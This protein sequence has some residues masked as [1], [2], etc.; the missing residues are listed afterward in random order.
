MNYNTIII[1]GGQAGL[2]VARYLKEKGIDY[3]VLDKEKEIG[4]SWKNRYD[5]L[6]LDSFAKY[7]KLENFPF[8]GNQKRQP[9]KDEVAEY[10]KSFAEFYDIKP[11]FDTEVY[12]IEKE[13]DDFIIKTN[14]DTYK[15]KSVVI[16]TGPFNTPY[17]PEYAYFISTEIY[18]LHAKNYKN[19]SEIPAGKILVVGGGNSGSEIA[20]ELVEN[21]RDIIFSFKG[22]LKSIPSSEFSQWIAYRLGIAHI[23]Q[24]SILGKIVRW[25]TKGK[26]VGMD[27]G[28]L[29]KNDRLTCTGEIIDIAPNG[30]IL[31]TTA[32]IDKVSNIIWATGYKNDFSIIKIKEF[33]ESLQNR[34]VSNIPGLYLLNIRWQHSKSSSHLAGISKDAK[35]IANTI[36]KRTY[37]G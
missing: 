34:G 4:A 22:K 6:V 30:D 11:V 19:S 29:L 12:S 36:Y 35:Y 32:K 8:Q 2:S 18:Q 3:I 24:K 20:K 26:A 5:S 28:M 17:I 7:S 9:T 10:L 27:V 31:S 14:K 33:D 13:G 1:G 15:S 23:P 25:Y 37:R 21:N 16:T